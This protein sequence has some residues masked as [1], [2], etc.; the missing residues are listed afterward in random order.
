[1]QRWQKYFIRKAND[2]VKSIRR[3]GTEM[4]VRHTYAAWH[5]LHSVFTTGL[6]RQSRD[7]GGWLSQITEELCTRILPNATKTLGRR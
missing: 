2:K 4:I 5:G 3:R 6:L 1:V 7:L